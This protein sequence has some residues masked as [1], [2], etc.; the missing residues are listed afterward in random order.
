MEDESLKVRI[1]DATL[2]EF[3]ENGAKFTMESVAKRLCISKKTIYTVFEDK[4]DLLIHVVEH[5]FSMVKKSESNVLKD[6]TLDIVEKL[7][8]VI[9]VLP[10]RFRKL[11][12]RKI[13]ALKDGYAD[14]LERIVEHINSEWEPTIDL[15]EEGI[16][17]GVLRPVNIPVFKVMIESSIKSFISDKEIIES[18]VTYEEALESMMD[19]I[20]SGIVVRE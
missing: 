10:D 18:G 7:R 1:M 4:K 19:I 20:M 12:F 17:Q 11:D 2:E 16:R 13:Y 14:V 3:N 6:E 8:R 9:I 5:G 15:M